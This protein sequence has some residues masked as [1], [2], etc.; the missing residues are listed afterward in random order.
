MSVSRIKA[1]LLEMDE[2][3]TRPLNASR[4]RRLIELRNQLEELEWE[5]KS[6]AA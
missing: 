3:R 2:V 6:K 1:L 4:E 5:Q